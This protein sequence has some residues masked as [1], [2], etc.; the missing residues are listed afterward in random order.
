MSGRSGGCLIVFEGIDGSGKSTQMRRAAAALRSAGWPVVEL[1]EPTHG[2][3]GC[4]IRALTRPGAQRAS[5]EEE[6]DLFVLDRQENVA[7]NIRPALKRGDVVLL[8]R[9]YFSTMAYQGARG[10]DPEAI[11]ARNEAFAPRPDGVLYFDLPVEVAL[12]RIERRRLAPADLFERRDYLERVKAIYD[13]LA[14]RLDY[15][16][17]IDAARDEESVAHDVMA[18]IG[19]ILRRI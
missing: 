7:Q 19:Q 16:F 12:E 11:R 9:Y 5:P 3:Y 13:D 8:D 18:A 1:V 4:Q 6:L 10:L 15:F 2:E 17:T 14:Q